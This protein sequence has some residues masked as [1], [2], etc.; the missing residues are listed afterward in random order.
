M[1][2]GFLAAFG[3]SI[4]AL[5]AFTALLAW[6]AWIWHSVDEG[7]FGDNPALAFAIAVAVCILLLGTALLGIPP[8]HFA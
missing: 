1:G 8:S 6:G 3:A 4:L 7:G 2:L 5:L